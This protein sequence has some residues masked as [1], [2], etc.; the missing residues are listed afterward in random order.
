MYIRDRSRRG[1][2]HKVYL[3]NTRVKLAK[4]VR[5][6]TYISETING[7]TNKFSENMLN[8][9]PQLKNTY[10]ILLIKVVQLF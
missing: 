2:P 7:T 6:N 10:L 3:I 5:M 8:Y 4:F 1:R 9:C